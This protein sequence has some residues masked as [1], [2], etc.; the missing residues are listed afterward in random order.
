MNDISGIDGLFRPFGALVLMTLVP[1][2]YAVG[3]IIFAAL[4][5]G[6]MQSKRA[7]IQA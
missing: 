5:L 4:R 1:T 2:A 6:A 3:Y 7:I